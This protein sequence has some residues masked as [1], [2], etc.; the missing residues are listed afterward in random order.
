MSREALSNGTVLVVGGNKYR[1]LKFMSEAGGSC[2]V[3]MAESVFSKQSSK[4]KGKKNHSNDDAVGEKCVIKEFYPK[5]Y[6]HDIRR[7]SSGELAVCKKSLDEFTVEKRR[8]TAGVARQIAYYHSNPINSIGCPE[9]YTDING[10]AYSILPL[11][12]GKTLK[13]TQEHSELLDHDIVEVMISLCE[14]VSELHIRGRLHLDIKPDNIYVFN[15]E[16]NYFRYIALFDFDTVFEKNNL[17]PKGFFSKGW[18]PWEQEYW[19][20]QEISEA[21]DIYAI[22]AVFYWLITGERITEDTSTQILRNDFSFLDKKT[23][24]LENEGAR[25]QIREILSFTLNR[26]PCEREINLGSIIYIFESLLA[27]ERRGFSSRRVSSS[28]KGDD[29]EKALMAEIINKN[30]EK[31]WRKHNA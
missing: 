1:I 5:E 3:Y 17:P 8:F 2:L 31:E 4:R 21:T 19:C 22:G 26:E 25:G 28:S 10:T 7:A 6:A 29:L 23:F 24:F 30:R 16:E 11:A 14:A 13:E 15:Q 18:S 20:V 12:N 27:P 9:S